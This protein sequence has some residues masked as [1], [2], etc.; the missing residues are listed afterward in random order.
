MINEAPTPRGLWESSKLLIEN[1]A[2]E[3]GKRN[4]KHKQRLNN[5]TSKKKQNKTTS[6][7]DWELLIDDFCST[8][9]LDF[10][11]AHKRT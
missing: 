9:P 3:I 1:F 6:L 10:V 5:K 2:S 4:R 11:T 7:D 8:K